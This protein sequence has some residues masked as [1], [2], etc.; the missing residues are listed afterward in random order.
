MST[1][2]LEKFE[3]L[4]E[5][6]MNAALDKIRLVGNLSNRVTYSYTDEHVRQIITTLEQEIERLKQRFGKSTSDEPSFRFQRDDEDDDAL[7]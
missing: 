4:A 6:R 7:N 1:D 2:K 3:R 5:K